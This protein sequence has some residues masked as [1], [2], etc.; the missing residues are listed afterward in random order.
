[1]F[2]HNICVEQPEVP[3]GMLDSSGPLPLEF[4]MNPKCPPTPTPTEATTTETEQSKLI[5]KAKELERS[6]LVEDFVGTP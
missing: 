2:K 3:I 5:K 4:F 1:M 6:A